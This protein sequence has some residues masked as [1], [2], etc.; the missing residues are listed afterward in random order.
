MAAAI[1]TRQVLQLIGFAAPVSQA[2]TDQGH[3][4]FDE[5][6]LLTDD[7]VDGLCKSI[8]SPGGLIPGVPA[9][10]GG[11][12][13]VPAAPNPGMLVSSRAQNNLKLLAYYLR[14]QQ[15]TSVAPVLAQITLANI[16][17]LRDQRD[18]EEAHTDPDAPVLDGDDWPKT[19][20]TLQEYLGACLGS[21]KLPLAYVVRRSIPATP[22]PATGWPSNEAHM[23]ACAPIVTNPAGAAAVGGVPI[24]TV[25]FKSDNKQ[26]W[27]KLASICRDKDCWTY[28]RRYQSTQNGRGAFWSLHD[29]YLG[30]S[31]VDNMSARA[32]RKLMDT[33]YTGEKRRWNF[34]KYIRLHVDQ[35]A[36]LEDLVQYGYSGIDEGSKVRYLVRGVRTQSLDTVKANILASAT[37]RN[38]FTAASG[39]FKDFIEQMK[40][41]Q[42][43]RDITIAGVGTG[44]GDG[45]SDSG[46]EQ[47]A[48]TKVKPDMNVDERYYS[49]KEFAN[50]TPEQKAGLTAKRDAR[51]ARDGGRKK[52]RGDRNKNK[53]TS[54][55]K[56]GR[57]QHVTLSKASIAA[58]ATAMKGANNDDNDAS[59]SSPE[60]DSDPDEERVPMKPPAKKQKLMNNRNNPALRRR[61]ST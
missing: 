29:H 8:R 35:H 28:M 55:G 33:T 34:E 30:A 39:L 45:D 44:A 18:Q 22:A 16:R 14:F 52:G 27:L 31:N 32:E 60:N 46:T 3:D 6:A 41:H 7:E 12:A 10:A 24:Y 26:V 19:I 54:T 36:I 56:Q 40:S 20:E 17:A 42:P 58:V 13:A 38:N 11:A 2:I 4:D 48:T 43:D 23:I 21:T 53:W 61:K 49:R 50:L 57:N 15:R 47:L 37:L 5:I 51:D 1:N 9:V 25:N 59:S